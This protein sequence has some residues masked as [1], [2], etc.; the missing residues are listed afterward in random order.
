MGW[1]G[2]FQ[3]SVVCRCVGI[4]L[5][6]FSLGRVQRQ[7]G[8]VFFII[9]VWVPVT[10]GRWCLLVWGLS[11]ILGADTSR[12]ELQP[13]DRRTRKVIVREAKKL[14]IHFL[15]WYWFLVMI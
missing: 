1:G 15:R 6:L 13:A 11:W 12:G 7:V 2:S 10:R 4:Q 5:S 9:R 3:F 14:F 8:W